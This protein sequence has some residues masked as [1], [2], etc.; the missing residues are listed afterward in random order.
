MWHTPGPLWFGEA[1][2][3]VA[4]GGVVH[5]PCAAATAEG[6][7]ATALILFVSDTYVCELVRSTQKDLLGSHWS[8]TRPL[9]LTSDT[10]FRGGVRGKGDSGYHTPGL[11]VVVTTPGDRPRVVKPGVWNTPGT[12]ISCEA[13][14]RPDPPPSAGYRI[15]YIRTRISS[16]HLQTKWNGVTTQFAGIADTNLDRGTAQQSRHSL[17]VAARRRTRRR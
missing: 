8:R 6:R 1:R 7:P 17:F 3:G 2:G 14:V 16:V 10:T 13:R 12:C 4:P 5:Y 11:V 15:Y 9:H